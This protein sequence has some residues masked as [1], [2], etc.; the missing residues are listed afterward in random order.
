MLMVFNIFV[1]EL[2][3]LM[4][5]SFYFKIFNPMKKIIY[6]KFVETKISY[7]PCCA[8]ENKTK[9]RE[10]TNNFYPICFHNINKLKIHL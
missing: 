1:L 8:H 5:F 6:T 4:R 7:T 10:G 9:T 3:V 2:V